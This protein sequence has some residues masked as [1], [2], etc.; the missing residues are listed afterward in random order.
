MTQHFGGRLK[1]E[2]AWDTYLCSTWDYIQKLNQICRYTFDR[3]I[4]LPYSSEWT[5]KK[6]STPVWSGCGFFFFFFM[7]IKPSGFQGRTL[8]TRVSW[9]AFFF[10]SEAQG[11]SLPWFCVVE[12][13]S[14]GRG[15]ASA[16]SWNRKSHISKWKAF[17]NKAAIMF[18]WKG[19]LPFGLRY[20]L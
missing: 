14:G 3:R 7:S 19:C 13:S 18:L 1:K 11:L 6:S 20:L 5:G 16:F 17:R 4:I 2:N 8:K 15:N 12:K 10:F 9:K